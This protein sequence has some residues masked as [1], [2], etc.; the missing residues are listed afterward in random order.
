MTTEDLAWPST[1]PRPQWVSAWIGEA[2]ALTQRT[3]PPQNRVNL[4]QLI[5]NALSVDDS[6]KD[7]DD[8][9]VKL[10]VEL[11]LRLFDFLTGFVVLNLFLLV[12]SI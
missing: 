10:V 12:T 2:Q 11:V 7:I 6:L 4:I 8:T 5:I 3:A 1:L 9:Q